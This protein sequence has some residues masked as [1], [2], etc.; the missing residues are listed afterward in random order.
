MVLQRQ[1]AC[2]KAPP[3][4][5]EL[6][7]PVGDAV[8]LRNQLQGLGRQGSAMLCALGGAQGVCR[9]LA[10]LMQAV[11][12]P[13]ACKVRDAAMQG[14]QLAAGVVPPAVQCVHVAHGR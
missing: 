11:P 7:L 10:D 2:T 13:S 8:R 6:Q 5:S 4:L 14:C 3:A 1:N 12:Q 9:L